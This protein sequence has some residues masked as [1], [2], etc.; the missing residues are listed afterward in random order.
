M[1]I[2]NVAN[3]KSL[4]ILT[5]LDKADGTADGK[6]KGSIWN[7]Y[8]KSEGIESGTLA[9]DITIPVENKLD[10][11][12]KIVIDK[13]EYNK[14]AAEAKKQGLR[15]TYSK[16]Y[17]YNETENMHY[18]KDAKTGKFVKC[19][20]ITYVAKD[21]S[22]TK[23]YVN[24]DGSKKCEQYDSDG[25][26]RNIELRTAGNRRYKNPDFVAKKLGL[27]R[28]FGSDNMKVFYDEKSKKHYIWNAENNS[29]EYNADV[30]NTNFVDA[31]DTYSEVGAVS[32][33]IK[34]TKDGTTVI[35][36][37]QLNRKHTTKYDTNGKVTYIDV[38]ENND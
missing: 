21:G 1:N 34:K 10:E 37:D 9:D 3:A 29:F 36:T 28:T 31:S 24:K 38:E 19:P 2:E 26:L 5:Q 4:Q 20:D 33:S 35:V 16:E 7:Q 11:I 23:Q 15:K 22:L 27:R 17:F 32:K 25:E 8:L 13:I 6:I 14:T 18:K 30:M 12:K